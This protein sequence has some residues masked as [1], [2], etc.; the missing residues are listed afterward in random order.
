[1]EQ[2]AYF[3]RTEKAMSVEQ[4]P[5]HE[6]KSSFCVWQHSNEVQSLLRLK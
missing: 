2:F 4:R 3:A 5:I 1:L 6:D